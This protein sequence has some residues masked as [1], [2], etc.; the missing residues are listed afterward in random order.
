MENPEEED[1]DAYDYASI[2]RAS[3]LAIYI[4]NEGLSCE[5]CGKAIDF[6]VVNAAYYCKHCNIAFHKKCFKK[7]Y[8]EDADL[9]CP[10]CG[11]ELEIASPCL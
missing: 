4:E 3:N 11:R 8:G 9:I 1:E 7:K 2:E 6:L 10:K 5:I